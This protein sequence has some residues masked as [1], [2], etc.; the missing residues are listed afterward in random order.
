MKKIYLALLT[1]LFAPCVLTA[2]TGIK[3][4]ESFEEPESGEMQLLMLKNGTTAYTNVTVDFIEVK[5]YD[6]ERK[7][8]GNRIIEHKQWTDRKMSA[9]NYLGTYE[10]NGKLVLFF[11][12]QMRKNTPVLKRV[13]LDPVNG[14]LLSS[15]VVFT[16]GEDRARHPFKIVQ[17]EDESYEFVFQNDNKQVSY[18]AVHFD[19]AHKQTRKAV[20]KI[21][22]IERIDIEN[23]SATGSELHIFCTNLVK[24]KDQQKTPL[25]MA[26]LSDGSNSFTVSKFD[27]EVYTKIAV[28]KFLYDAQR[29]IYIAMLMGEISTESKS[30]L[31]TNTTERTTTYGIELIFINPATPEVLGQYQIGGKELNDHAT[32]YMHMKDGFTGLYDTHVLTPDGTMDILFEEE[33]Y[34]STSRY[35]VTQNGNLGL[36]HFDKDFKLDNKY[37]IRKAQVSRSGVMGSGKVNEYFSYSYFHTPTTRYI[38]YNDIPENFRHPLKDEPESIKAITETNAVLYKLSDGNIE[39][40]YLFGEP[41]DKKSSKFSMN[42]SAIYN[43]SHNTY[44]TLMV[45]N[46]RG[47]KEAHIAWIT[48][49]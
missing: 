10:V 13:I 22:G 34:V 25:Y 14:R 28:S 45:D 38:V 6:T 18:T 24:G 47:R 42:Q 48:F 23:L 46:Q 3:Y 43:E 15:D 20:L 19:T 4:S 12:Q 39:R 27:A 8:T 40:S 41:A 11:D 36:L 2:Q 35:T 30:K 16:L 49:E 1:I 33:Y 31:L 9:T 29:G 7:R 17:F 26:K 21:D 5:L 37:I 32:A 44:L